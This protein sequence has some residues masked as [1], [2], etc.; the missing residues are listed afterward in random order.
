MIL[1][2][3]I[4]SFLNNE[5]G[6]K[7]VQDNQEPDIKFDNIEIIRSDENLGYARGNNLGIRFLINKGVDN[8]LVL[9][10]DILLTNNFITPLAD[11]LKS[12][13]EIGLI[14]PLLF[15]DDGSIDY[16]CCRRSPT[17]KSLIFESLQYLPGLKNVINKNYVLIN[18]NSLSNNGLI[19]CDIVSGSCIMARAS[20]WQE[21]NYFDENTFLYYEENILFE[22]LKHRNLKTALL[23]SV[24]VIHLGAVSVKKVT[25]VSILKIALDSLLYYLKSYRSVNKF[26]IATIKTI[27][28][29]QIKL[30][31]I[32]NLLKNK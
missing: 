12:H 25:N 1:L 16:N 28:L 2:I 10:N 8:I 20:T 14:S 11:T 19:Y 24:S 13:P 4:S 31:S 21:I 7:S 15:K 27:R 3:S 29:L 32:K 9:N 22:K 23:T 5:S 26:E 18:K 6:Y 17:I 30:L